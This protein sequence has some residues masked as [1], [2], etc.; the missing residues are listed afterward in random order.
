MG[1]AW[2][3]RAALACAALLAFAAPAHASTQIGIVAT[4]DPDNCTPNTEF[5]QNT[6]GTGGPTPSYDV[7]FAGVITSW[8]TKPGSGTGTGARLKVYRP[9]AD[10]STWTVVGESAAKIL[11]PDTVNTA[12]TRIPVQAADRIA[13]RTAS[14]NGGPCDFP[15]PVGLGPGY[16]IFVFQSMTVGF[17]PPAGSNV[18]FTDDGLEELV[19]IAAVVEPDADGDGFGDETQDQC[20]G[21]AGPNS[22]CPAPAPAP[23]PTPPAPQPQ[24]PILH[25]TTAA[26]HT[27]RVLKQHGIVLAA[28]PNVA[29]T[30]SATATVSLP[31]GST[32]VRFKRAT[33][34]VAANAK[35]TLKLALPKSRLG[36]VKAA[37]RRHRKL[38]ARAVLT[39]TASGSK[40]SV[41][42]FKIHLTP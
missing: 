18:T 27:Q 12:A 30:V 23:T 15:Y 10:P 13:I 20:P 14:G 5:M 19:N 21:V 26:K 31:A 39:T 40:A 38:V 9:T 28:Q 37:L 3:T 6:V 32:V 17:D 33:K 16:A 11:T 29:S 42:R 41:T 2:S 36:R 4:S 8:S 24:A 25:V 34:S 22:G 35:V 7:P 1:G